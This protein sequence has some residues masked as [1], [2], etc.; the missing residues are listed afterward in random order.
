MLVKLHSL[1]WMELKGKSCKHCQW[2]IGPF[3]VLD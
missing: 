1:E 2:W 3:S